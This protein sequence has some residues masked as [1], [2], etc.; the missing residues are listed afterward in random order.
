VKCDLH[1]H[2]YFSG[3]CTTPVVGKLCRESYS[4]PDK[5]YTRLK[6]RGMN[7]F[8]LTDHDSIEGAE[9]LRSHPDFFVSEELTCKM[10]SGSEVHIGVYDVSER[11]HPQ[12]LRRRGDLV[13]LLM[14]LSEQRL[15]FSVN[16]V[17]SSLTGERH[18]EDFEW[19]ERYFPNFE[20]KN[21]H[22][23]DRA[24][25]DAAKLAK[26]WGKIGIGGSDAHALPSVATAYTE[27]PGAR[28]KQEFFDGLRNGLG[29]VAGSSGCFSKLT[30]DVYVIAGEMMREKMWTSLLAPLAVLI[31]GFTL[32]NYCEEWLFCRRWAPQVLSQPQTKNRCHWI[33]G[34]QNVAEE[35]L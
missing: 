26:Q 25:L 27:V 16:H 19:F 4:A 18:L 34:P 1:V 10:P 24:N 13:A 11:Q 35:S 15:F 22:M 6:H 28:D 31:P 7:L 14:Y 33:S 32:W 8:T 29:R 9:M 20:I 3:P 23:L 12:L 21:G 2:S 5:I 17:F 30:L